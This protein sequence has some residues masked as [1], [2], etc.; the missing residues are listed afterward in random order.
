MDRYLY[1]SDKLGIVG[2]K[3]KT[4]TKAAK[5]QYRRCRASASAS[6]SFIYFVQAPMVAQ[7]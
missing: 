6:A 5:Q 3:P 1:A 7:T 2:A 4:K